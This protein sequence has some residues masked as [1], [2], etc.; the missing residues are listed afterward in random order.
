MNKEIDKAIIRLKDA[1]KEY[2]ED[3][4]LCAIKDTRINESLSFLESAKAEI[5]AF[6]SRAKEI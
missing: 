5:E 4:L 3:C 2:N 6:V 1:L